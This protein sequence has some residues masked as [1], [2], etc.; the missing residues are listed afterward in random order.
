MFKIIFN[1]L[2]PVSMC[3]LFFAGCAFSWYIIVGDFEWDLWR[4]R[5]L[6]FAMGIVVFICF[7]VPVYKFI[8]LFL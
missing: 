5:A 2:Y 6:I 1:I 3:F 7:Y 8:H 4:E